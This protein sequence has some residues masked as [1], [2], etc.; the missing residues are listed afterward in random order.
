MRNLSIPA[1]L[2][3]FVLDASFLQAASLTTQNHSFENPAT[4]DGT[5][6]ASDTSAPTGWEIYGSTMVGFRFFGVLDPAGTTL[7]SEPVPDGENV[8]VVFFF[9][10]GSD[11]GGLE[12][13]LGDN[14]ELNTEYTLTVDVGN[15]ANDPNPPH[16]SFDF[17]GFPGYRIE[18][19]AGGNVIAADDNSLLI[20]EGAFETSSIQFTTGG[21]HAHA[22]Q[23]L[24]IRLIN[25]NGSGIEVNFDDVVLNAIA[26][27][28][29][30][31]CSF[32]A[33]AVVMFFVFTKR[34]S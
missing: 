11:E 20:G 5:F 28:E 30:S 22:G 34:R 32:V 13:T 16:N 25:L 6:I 27:P 33:G 4:G 8:G 26:I 17:S 12:Q 2:A 1:L 19:L 7:Y 14:L 10:P 23:A 24:G 18:L 31:A 15:I 29:P 3:I 9:T 21:A